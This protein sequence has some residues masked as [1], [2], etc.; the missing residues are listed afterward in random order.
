MSYHAY[1]QLIHDTAKA[2]GLD[3][4]PY[5]LEEHQSGLVTLVFDAHEGN[6]QEAD[7]INLGYRRAG[8][9][10]VISQCLDTLDADNGDVCLL[11]LQHN[12]ARAGD[13][14]FAGI[15]ADEDNGSAIT[16]NLC[17][18]LDDGIDAEA[19]LGHISRF[20]DQ[21]SEFIKQAT[22][23]EQA[24]GAQVPETGAVKV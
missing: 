4:Y 5:L 10:L 7:I 12:G 6:G 20:M 23:P 16:F 19:L 14:P 1:Q 13:A 2:L 24:G 18:P 9:E 15:V 11:A 8:D 17:L 21:S 22:A 3:E